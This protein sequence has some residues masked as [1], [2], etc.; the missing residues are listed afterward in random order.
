M[1][2]LDAKSAAR[3]SS[4]PL[5]KPIWKSR[6]PNAAKAAKAK[7]DAK[8]SSILESL[9]K[10][11]VERHKHAPPPEPIGFAAKR[12]AAISKASA[13]WVSEGARS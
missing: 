5:A 3:L 11:V 8:E 7:G 1:P 9:I 4:N 6:D 10:P 13:A 12:F 2:P